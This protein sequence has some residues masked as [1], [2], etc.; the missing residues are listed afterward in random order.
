MVL[1]MVREVTIVDRFPITP[2]AIL[3]LCRLDAKEV[4]AESTRGVIEKPYHQ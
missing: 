4:I 2:R 3:R 1:T